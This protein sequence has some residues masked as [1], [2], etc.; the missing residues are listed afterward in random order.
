MLTFEEWVV[1]RGTHGH[2]I[3]TQPR[4]FEAAEKLRD[5]TFGYLVY[6]ISLAPNGRILKSLSAKA[7]SI[8]DIRDTFSGK[9][10]FLYDIFRSTMVD[11]SSF[12]LT[13]SWIV[14]YAVLYE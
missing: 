1:N 6:P 2:Y 7:E 5:V 4:D 8:D 3:P 10:I 12:D 9:K 13:V 11:P 14:R